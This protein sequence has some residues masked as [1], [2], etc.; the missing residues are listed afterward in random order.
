MP[1]YTDAT[2]T[3]M[4]PTILLSNGEY[5]DYTRPAEAKYDIGVIAH[6][7]GNICRFTGQVSKF[8]S[9]A[10]HSVNVS[11]IVAPE[12]AL[13]G[14]MH[15][16]SEAFMVD[17]PKPLKMLLP[18]YQ[19]IEELVDRSVMD[20]FGLPYPMAPPVKAADRVA[21]FLEQRLLMPPHGDLWDVEVEY[22]QSF[23]GMRTSREV[24]ISSLLPQLAERLFLNR[25]RELAG[26]SN[27]PLT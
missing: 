16:A 17:V 1:S 21:L 6:A 10:E 27:V 3:V 12:H 7:L 11:H 19:A 26:V 18:D 14:L 4:T 25:F 24:K 2:R 15:D 20:R 5:F 9:V 23:M 22:A 8:Y 13:A